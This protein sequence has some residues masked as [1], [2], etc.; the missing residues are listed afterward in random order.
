[1]SK[2]FHINPMTNNISECSAKKKCAF[3]KTEGYIEQHFDNKKEAQQYLEQK[4]SKEHNITKKLSKKHTKKI[5]IRENEKNNDMEPLAAY[6]VSQNTM[7]DKTT[8]RFQNLQDNEK[9]YM[10]KILKLEVVNMDRDFSK[11][12]S[13]FNVVDDSF[14]VSYERTSLS[15]LAK[16]RSEHSVAAALYAEQMI[17]EDLSFIDR[18]KY[19]KLYNVSFI[20]SNIADEIIQRQKL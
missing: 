17:N 19:E 18:R 8:L 14:I 2:S 4:L 3:K 11:I 1:M 7:N 15:T 5:N 9:N 10:L 16:V 20:L 6:N 12:Q 13:Y